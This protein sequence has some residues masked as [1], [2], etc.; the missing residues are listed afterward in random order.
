MQR[1]VLKENWNEFDWELELRKDDARVNRYINELPRYID[2]PDEDG[3]IMQRMKKC[4]E[5]EPAG[6]DWSA[7]GPVPYDNSDDPEENDPDDPFAKDSADWQNVDGSKIYMES[8]S[9]AKDWSVF[10]ASRPDFA[11]PSM[12]ILCLYGK[13]MARSA[14]VIEMS[15]DPETEPDSRMLKLALMKR[16]L[17]DLNRLIGVF[18][19]LELPEEEPRIERHMS[20]LRD[21]AEMLRDRIP[22]LRSVGK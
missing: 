12:E 22:A 15:L 17:S 8:S 21:L 14:D 11:A 13:L 2:L 7:I 9:L 3:V 20:A 5:L 1:P 4:P 19:E 10:Y 16:L 6:G 18:L